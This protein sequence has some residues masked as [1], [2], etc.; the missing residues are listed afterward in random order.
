MSLRKKMPGKRNRLSQ[1]TVAT[2]CNMDLMDLLFSCSLV[3]V[4][5]TSLGIETVHL[6]KEHHGTIL[7]ASLLQ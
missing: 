7:V 2:P 5:G 3:S 6:S 1:H 4:P